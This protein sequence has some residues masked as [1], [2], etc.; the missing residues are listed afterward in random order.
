[1]TLTTFIQVFLIVDVF[2]IG[3]LTAVGTRHALMHYRPEKHEPEQAPVVVPD[4]ALPAATKERLIKETTLHY[5]KV[6]ESSADVLQGDLKL[7]SEKINDLLERLAAEIVG[8]ELER[9][10]VELNRLHTQVV[11]DM[12]GIKKQMEGS[13]AEIKAQYAAAYEL[14]KQ[15]MI[16]QIDARLGDAVGSFLLETLQHNVDLG[17]QEA[18]LMALLEEHKEDF[19][20]A[21]TYEV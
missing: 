11:A 20:K 9:Y 17:A 12:G 5:Q 14:E 1:M 7:T 13:E 2:F 19:K 15:N 3:F 10:R 21:V 4:I 8:N 6:L 16:K 18:Y